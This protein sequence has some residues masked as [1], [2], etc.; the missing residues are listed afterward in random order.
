VERLD[1][2]LDQDHVPEGVGDPAGV[3]GGAS[4]L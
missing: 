2:G 1:I 4:G 3:S